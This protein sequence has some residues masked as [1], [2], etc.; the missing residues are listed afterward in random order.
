MNRI[1][2]PIR[3]RA[4][5]GT[6]RMLGRVLAACARALH[7]AGVSPP[8][9]DAM[10]RGRVAVEHTDTVIERLLV[11]QVLERPGPRSRAELEVTLG[12]VEPLAISDALTAL[13]AE[14]VLYTGGEQVWASRCVRYLD[15]RGF[16]GV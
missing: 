2:R 11:L 10:F 6:V 16:I 1:I 3:V 9:I 15:E 5:E 7:A 8:D 12:D 13:E 14:G 4:L